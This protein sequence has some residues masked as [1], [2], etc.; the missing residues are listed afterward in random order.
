[1]QVAEMALALTRTSTGV[2]LRCDESMK[3]ENTKKSQDENVFVYIK[4]EV[5]FQREILLERKN[6]RYCCFFF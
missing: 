3:D 1:V 2:K 4:F 6:Y 5:M